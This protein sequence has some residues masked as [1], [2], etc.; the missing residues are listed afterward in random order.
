MLP[1]PHYVLLSG[2]DRLGPRLIA[3]TDGSEVQAVYGFSDKG[4]YD[5]FM[6]HSPLPLRPYPLVTGYLRE[7]GY[8]PDGRLHLVVVDAHGQDDTCLQAARIERLEEAQRKREP[9]LLATHR[10]HYSPS[11]RAYSVEEL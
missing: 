9:Q 3:A 7:P 11:D 4:P 5:Q 8:V 6:T 1:T 2:K 10:L